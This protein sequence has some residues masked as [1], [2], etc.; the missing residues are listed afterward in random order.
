MTMQSAAAVARM[1]EAECPCKAKEGLSQRKSGGVQ[2][3]L[4]ACIGQVRLPAC[5]TC[6][7]LY[8]AY[9]CQSEHML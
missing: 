5:N 9:R 2:V 8:K 4:L 6:M 1:R 7:K 3:A